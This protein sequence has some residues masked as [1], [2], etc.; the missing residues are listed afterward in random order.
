MQAQHLRVAEVALGGIT[1]ANV[2]AIYCMRRECARWYMHNQIAPRRI[3]GG[4]NAL[5]DNGQR[6]VDTEVGD[7]INSL[8]EPVQSDWRRRDCAVY[9]LIDANDDH[10]AI[11]GERGEIP[12]QLS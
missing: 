12:G 3:I 2:S 10:S 8:G 5:R 9:S 7:L 6:R 11:D 1:T 4:P